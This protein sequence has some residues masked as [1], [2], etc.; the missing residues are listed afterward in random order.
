MAFFSCARFCL[1]KHAKY[2]ERR[3]ICIKG[4]VNSLKDEEK[5]PLMK[6]ISPI[7]VYDKNCIIVLKFYFYL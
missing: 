6:S 1:S 3:K 5:A 4:F 7:F 2:N